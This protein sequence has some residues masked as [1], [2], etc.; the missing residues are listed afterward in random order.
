MALLHIYSSW[1][2]WHSIRL[3][4]RNLVSPSCLTKTPHTPVTSFKDVV[5]YQI[6]VNPLNQQV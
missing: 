5:I 4:G 3:N 6:L 1:P 2:G